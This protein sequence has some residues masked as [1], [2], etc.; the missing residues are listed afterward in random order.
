MLKAKVVTL[1]WDILPETLA[2]GTRLTTYIKIQLYM[3]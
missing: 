1:H 2:L 3:N